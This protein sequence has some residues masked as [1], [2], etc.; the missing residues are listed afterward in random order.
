[1]PRPKGSKNRT[2][3]VVEN[4]DEKIAAAEAEIEKLTADL[5]AKKAELKTLAKA[6]LKADKA[7][8]AKQAE[9]EK[10]KLL[11]AIEKSGKSVDEIIDLLK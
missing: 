8:A 2:K 1:M 5:K 7:A 6:K 10:T 9:E 11:E 3:P 4:V